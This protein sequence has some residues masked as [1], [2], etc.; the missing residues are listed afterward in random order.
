MEWFERDDD[1]H[2]RTKRSDGTM[3]GVIDPILAKFGMS[4]LRLG[5]GGDQDVSEVGGDG[6]S[7]RI[8]RSMLRLNKERVSE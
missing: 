1:L 5:V 2:V 6:E 3:Q 7:F 8:D 4:P